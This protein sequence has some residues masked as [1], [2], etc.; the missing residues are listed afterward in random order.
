MYFDETEK[1]IDCEC[2]CYV[3]VCI[4]AKRRLPTFPVACFFLF[5]D[6]YFDKCVQYMAFDCF[7]QCRMKFDDE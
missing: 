1:K 5:A 6:M 3:Y 2:V 7:C 4:Y